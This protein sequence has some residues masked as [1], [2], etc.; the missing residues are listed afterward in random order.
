MRL[1][2]LAIHAGGEYDLETGALTPPIH[3]ATTF[4][5]GPAAE[6]IAGYEYQREGNPTNDRLRAAVAALEG[7]AQAITFA[8]GMAAITT[9]LE[10]LRP[11]TR[12]IIPSD[13]YA[14]LRLL[15]AEYL[16][17][18]GMQVQ[19]LDMTD[20]AAVTAACANGID[21]IWVETPSNPMMQ[22]SDIAAL[23]ALAHTHGALLVADNTFASPVLQQ[24]LALGADIVMHSTTKYFGGHSDVLGGAL[25]FAREDDLYRAVAHRLHI[26]GAVMAPFNAWLTLRGCR[27]LPARM[28]LHCSNAKALAEFLSAQPQVEAVHYPGLPSH[29]AYD[30]AKRQMRDGGGMLSVQIA[31][32]REATLAVAGA[33]KLFTNATSLGG[34]ESLVE[35][36]ASVEGAASVTPHNL[37]RVS[38]GLEH[39]DDLVGDFAQALAQA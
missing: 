12:L 35:H 28:A 37:L 16:P 22:V 27:S 7:A 1:E 9:L 10:T 34:C 13:C 38:V 14:G 5:H 30:L 26:T 17:E 36:R 4:R 20:L 19:R 6:R 39:I 21:V 3:L 8:S 31:G 15:A 25:A 23:A 2:T 18:R 29:P 11:G 32:G 24:P 33:L